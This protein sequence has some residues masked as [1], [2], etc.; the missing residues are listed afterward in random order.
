[1]TC[2]ALSISPGTPPNATITVKGAQD[3]WITWV[4]GTEY[5]LDAGNEVHSF[6]YQGPDPHAALMKLTS[7]SSSYASLLAQH[8]ADFKATISDKFSLSLGQ[9]AQLDVPTDVLRS[10]YTTDVGNPYLE[11]LIFNYGRYLL[12]SSAR[13]VLPANLQGKWASDISNPW[14]AGTRL[15]CS[16]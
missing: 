13:G 2:Q 1:M 9:K 4:G 11:W 8:V 5:S 16:L 14:S 15:Y 6:S 12:G 3:A 10:Q 7:S